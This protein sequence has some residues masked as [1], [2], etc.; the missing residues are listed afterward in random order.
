M[1]QSARRSQSLGLQRMPKKPFEAHRPGRL[2]SLDFSPK[3]RRS[4]KHR[5]GL[6]GFLYRG[7]QGSVAASVGGMRELQQKG[8]V[9]RGH[10]NAASACTN[11]F[12]QVH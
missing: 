7:G 6:K 4:P 5:E 1:K 11:F 9:V 10:K 2:D 3:E 12:E 8:I